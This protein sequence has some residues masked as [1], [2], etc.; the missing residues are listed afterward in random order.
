MFGIASIWGLFSQAY[1]TSVLEDKA[2]TL[3]L[4]TVGSV[5]NVCLNVLSPVSVLTA[6]FGT[7][8]NYALGS[9]LMALGVILTGFS[10]EIWHIYLSQGVLYGFGCAF[11]YM[12]MYR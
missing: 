8:F 10:Y 1:A 6:R 3:A 11:V 12:V 4:M 9:V 5:T 7:R 2:S